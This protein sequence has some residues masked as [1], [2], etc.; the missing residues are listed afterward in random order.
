MD[1][2][3]KL[4]SRAMLGKTA[5]ELQ[6][7]IAAVRGATGENTLATDVVESAMK[8]SIMLSMPSNADTGGSTNIHGPA[9]LRADLAAANIPAALLRAAFED[10][11]GEAFS[12]RDIDTASIVLYVGMLIS[13]AEVGKLA[14]SV[15]DRKV[16]VYS[17]VRR[18]A[19]GGAGGHRR[20][21]DFKLVSA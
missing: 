8:D 15:R 13:L 18:W 7:A 6:A 2:L 9:Q 4:V 12:Y 5:E 10:A 19:V 16:M 3:R 14:H 11:H 17:D 21:V 1:A 20:A